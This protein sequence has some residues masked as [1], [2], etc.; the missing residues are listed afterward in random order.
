V[1]LFPNRLQTRPGGFSARVQS[2]G[3]LGLEELI[4]NLVRRTRFH[5][6]PGEMLRIAR[7]IVAE[8]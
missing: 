3:T 5:G 4:A 2:G 1:R 6:D 8:V 7:A